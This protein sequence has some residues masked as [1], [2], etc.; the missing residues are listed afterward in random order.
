MRVAG[1]GAGDQEKAHERFS[2][3]GLRDRTSKV[4]SFQVRLCAVCNLGLA[5][6][7]AF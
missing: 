2:K 7:C 4:C 5:R 6:C 1:A 3:K